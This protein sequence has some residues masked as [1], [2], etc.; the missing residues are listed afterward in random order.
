MVLSRAPVRAVGW[1]PP[2]GLLHLGAVLDGMDSVAVQLVDPILDGSDEGSAIDRIMAFEP[3]LVGLSVHNMDSDDSHHMALQLRRRGHQGPIVFGGPYVFSFGRRV[4]RDT[5]VDFAVIGEGEEALRQLVECLRSDEPPTRVPNLIHRAPGDGTIMENARSELEDI[6]TVPRPDYGL[7]GIEDIRP[8]AQAFLPHSL[9]APSPRAVPFF[10]SRGCSFR[11]SFCC[12]HMGGRIRTHGIARVMED[13]DFYRDFG[14][15]YIQFMDSQIGGRRRLRELFTAIRDRDDDLSYSVYMGVRVEV[16]DEGL[17]DLMSQAGVKQIS[18]SMDAAAPKVQEAM[19]K[20]VP[21]AE[22]HRVL[23][24]CDRLGLLTRVYG[25]LGYLDETEEE[26]LQTVETICGLPAD[27]A[28]FAF[29]IPYPGTR[30]GDEV[31]ERGIDAHHLSRQSVFDVTE[32]I[33]AVPRNRLLDL[34]KHAYRRFYLDPRRWI[35][36]AR[37]MPLSKVSLR[38]L[39][40]PLRMMVKDGSRFV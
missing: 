35:R 23:A 36:V 37:K 40:V 12:Q 17:L 9:L 21:Q 24:H 3:D 16:L 22:I 18:L 1:D 15:E 14:A 26:I 20:K 7:L 5:N 6:D 8:V 11:C 39:E 25:M 4:L 27:L 34:R 33:A 10:S 28:I 32:G 29:P 19:N 2:I 13:L 30:F 38:A 31:I